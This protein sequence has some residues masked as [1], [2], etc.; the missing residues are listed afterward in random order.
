MGTTIGQALPKQLFIRHFDSKKR[1]V[2]K[3]LL[4]GMPDHLSK[5]EYRVTFHVG[6]ASWT[7]LS[8]ELKE[9]FQAG[10]GAG[11]MTATRRKSALSHQSDTREPRPWA[12]LASDPVMREPF[13][14]LRAPM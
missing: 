7:N 10:M 5:L 13:P 8:L 6:G 1:E 4:P 3:F 9:F 12:G 11:P 14:S 2:Q